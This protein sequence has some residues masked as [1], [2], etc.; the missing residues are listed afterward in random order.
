MEHVTESIFLTG[1]WSNSN[2]P[3]APKAFYQGVSL[4]FPKRKILDSSKLTK[5]TDDI[6]KFDEMAK[7]YQNG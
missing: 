7:S 6:L 4:P 1:I 2:Q 3:L 5:F